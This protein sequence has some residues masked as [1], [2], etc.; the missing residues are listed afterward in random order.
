MSSTDPADP[1][2][3]E[4]RHLGK[5]IGL[6]LAPLVFVAVWFLPIGLDQASHRLAAVFGAVVILWVTEALPIA[7]TA[8]LIAPLIVA[9]GVADAK[10]AFAPYADPLLFLFVG[11]FF[12]ARAMARHGLDRRIASSLVSLKAVGNSPLRIRAAFMVTGALLSMWISN[13]ATTAILV[14]ILLGTFASGQRQSGSLLAVAYACSIGGL[15]TLVGSPPNGITARLLTNA[16]HPFEFVEWMMIGV[17]TAIVCLALVFLVTRKLSPPGE[18]PPMEDEEEVELAEPPAARWTRGEK[19]VLLSFALAVVGWMVP[20]ILKSAG[21]E[22]GTTLSRALPGGVVAL[23][24]SSVLF[25]F[26]DRRGELVLPWREAGRIDWGIIMLFG[27]GLSLGQQMADTGLADAVARAFVSSTGITDL[28]AL[29]IL[30]A[31]G[32]IFFTEVCSN[33][34]SANILVPIV[35]AI[36]AEAGVSPLPPALAVGLAAS[37]AFMLPIATGPNAIVYG[38]GK[39]TL[40][41]MMKTGFWLNLACGLVI[42]LVLWLLL[43]LYGWI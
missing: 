8:L 17:P 20:G 16:G 27:G 9:T 30:I 6:A 14:P 36:A 3:T 32:T 1:G 25:V 40:P 23:F 12:I 41:E 37:C 5:K 19:V 11:G 10:T 31:V 18:R 24:A 28:W 34:A 7:A 15:G 22:L 13:T 33:T 29:T 42:V 26:R 43:P 35:I 39:V 21:T 2:S 4:R 38:S